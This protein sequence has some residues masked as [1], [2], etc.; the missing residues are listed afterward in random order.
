M[1]GFMKNHSFFQVDE[2]SS[3]LSAPVM[4]GVHTSLLMGGFAVIPN[5]ALVYVVDGH[6][7]CRIANHR[8]RA[9]AENLIRSKT[10]A[11]VLAVRARPLRN[12]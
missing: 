11:P 6:Q 9:V 8:E 2:V 12:D 1:T 5:T 3:D 4:Y 10:A 7:E